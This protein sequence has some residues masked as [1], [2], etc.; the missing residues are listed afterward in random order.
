MKK[1]LLFLLISCAGLS[2]CKKEVLIPGSSNR[3]ILA[4]IAANSW[5][6]SSDG[7]YYSTVINVPENN[8]NFNQAGHIL[9]SMSFENPDVYEGLPQ[10][11]AGDSY[12][13]TSKP[14]S[15]TIYINDAYNKV[16]PVP[17]NGITTAKITLV[18]AELID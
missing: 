15:V 17:P 3:T 2:S 10:V 7:L 4:D 8:A 12:T 13:F 9:V 6:L 14:G 16:R 5:V 11:Y 1:Y 18:D